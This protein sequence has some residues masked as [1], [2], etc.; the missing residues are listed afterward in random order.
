MF[1]PNWIAV[2]FTIN[3]ESIEYSARKARATDV[4]TESKQ[5][6]IEDRSQAH[7]CVKDAK[8]IGMHFEYKKHSVFECFLPDRLCVRRLT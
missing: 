5:R 7:Y 6:L 2:S 1:L 4:E 3:V 8:K